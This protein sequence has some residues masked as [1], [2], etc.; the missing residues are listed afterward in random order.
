MIG[1]P[2]VLAEA[3]CCDELVDAFR[4]RKAALGLSNE[5]IDHIC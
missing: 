4:S 3:T 1:P 2:Q 5:A